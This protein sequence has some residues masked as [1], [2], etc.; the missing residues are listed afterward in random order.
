[1]SQN[2]DPEAIDKFNESIRELNNNMPSFILGINQVMGVASGSVKASDALKK[3]SENAKELTALEEAEA[4]TKKKKDVI[5]A[6]R[7]RAQAQATDA[8]QK[9]A[10]GLTNTSTEFAKFNG[11]LGSA[12]DAALSIG[13][14]FGLLGLAIGG[15]IK[16]TTMAAQ[17]ATKQ[18]D[19][20]LK[21]T[22]EFNKM[23]AAGGLT[24]K[25][26]AEMG[27]KIGLSNEQ[28]ASMPKALKRAGDS[29][30]SLGATTADGQKKLMGM[31]AVTN[32]QREAFQRLGIGQE[33]LMERQA[34]Y[35]ALQRASGMQLVGNMKTEAGLQK[36]SLEYT[37]N[38]LVL[39]D[40]TGQDVDSVAAQQKQAQAAYEIQL[41]N[42]RLTR[43]IKKAEAEGN[44]DRANQLRAEKKSRDDTL[45]IVTSIGDQDLT[46]G[47]QK[48]FATGAITEQSAMYVQMGID[49]Q[50]FRKRMQEGEDI[51]GEFANAL[52]DAVIKKNEEIGT[53]AAYNKEVG[54]T[55]GQTEKILAFAAANAETDFRNRKKNA[56][57]GVGAPE[58]GK[59]GK[60]S[61]DDPAQ[62]ARNVLT[63]TTIEVNR[64]LEKMLLA[65]NPLL[66]GFN[67]LTITTTALTAAAGLA[68]IALGY[69][70]AKAGIGKAMEAAGNTGGAG[71]GGK[72]GG[73]GDGGYD[74]NTPPK[75]G[76]YKDANGRWRDSSGKF[77]S[78]PPSEM[79][80]AGKGSGAA[81]KALSVLGK[82]AGPASG[83]LAIGSGVMNATM[84]YNDVEGQVKSG[85]LTEKEGTVKKSEAV[86]KGAGEAAGGAGGAYAGAIGG[87]A[88]GSIV[89]VVGTVI[90]GILGAALGGWLGS[91]GGEIIGEKVGTAAGEAISKDSD[92][93]K[94]TETAA[95]KAVDTGT[96]NKPAVA[97]SAEPE[98]KQNVASTTRSLIP[99]ATTT[100]KQSITTESVNITTD[101]IYVQAK[102]DAST[103]NKPVAPIPAKPTEPVAMGNEGRRGATST[104]P[105]AT[106]VVTATNTTAPAAQ[107]PIATPVTTENESRRSA[108]STT[109]AMASVVTATKTP[110]AT[111]VVTATNT[112]KTSVTPPPAPTPVA[113]GNEGRR[114]STNSAPTAAPVV[115]A[116]KT[117]ISS[118][119][120]T[121]AS[122]TAPVP[123][124]VPVAMATDSNKV[125]KPSSRPPEESGPD[126]SVKAVDLA[127]ILKFGSNSGTRENF[128]ALQPTFKDAV[129]AAATEYNA[130]TG[131]MIM[132]NSAKRA[133]EDQ[134]RIW[135]ESVAAGRP[136]VSPTGMT[137]GKPGRSLHEK[138]EA[139][140]IQNYKDS[141]AIAAFN[142]QGLSQKVPR[143]P[144][145]FQAREGAM[146][147]GPSS[148]YPVEA[149]FHGNEIVAP[150]D[151]ESILTKLS[152]TSVSEMQKETNYTTSNNSSTETVVSSNAE[153]IDLMKMFVEKMDDFIDAQSDSNSIQSELLQY[154]KV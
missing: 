63:T 146:V 94:A 137:I 87:A 36:A 118:P 122:T 4:Q 153:M 19:N 35:V 26:I 50:G 145:H 154:S 117:P 72:G 144:V 1:M 18:A 81:S 150:L 78:G 74:P 88:I 25:T 108:T 80:S 41:D 114:G 67:A 119:P 47:L 61:E 23:G 52:R 38:L 136:G 96:Q 140:D 70:A 100:N 8:L 64:A 34:D 15:L 31:L 127:K 116:T 20:A 112:T 29:I 82:F 66:T 99:V 149:T 46:A 105:T 53:A 111:P 151:P 107:P 51:S 121:T 135:D 7:N 124:A 147:N 24:A 77:S 3:L 97:K 71:K 93:A 39:A 59:T 60:T 123:T 126:T 56:E 12:G 98:N 28:F 54:K 141:A 43:E 139:V 37:K 90:G 44:T 84:G 65:T 138:G 55:F 73:K 110:T 83:A 58:A 9:F 85:E 113:W 89:P 10:H 48:F 40:I 2:L 133:S 42:Y 152:K 106:P 33:E 68:A 22:D 148:G 11:A 57:A 101:K 76:H 109:P 69:M 27:I 75:E 91:K 95:A 125:S 134:Q 16:A 21:A 130:V 103:T 6:N 128:E 13:K 115:T 49:M 131:N 143:D 129:I 142:K 104:A 132:I 5:D 62:K 86:G 79:P 17:A 102:S 92:V 14:N 120:V 45:A 32:S 30:V